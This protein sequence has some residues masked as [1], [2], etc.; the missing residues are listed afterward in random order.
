MK[1]NNLSKGNSFRITHIRK[2][3]ELLNR[4]S[5]NQN[6]NA[7][8]IQPGYSTRLELFEIDD[9]VISIAVIFQA[10]VAQPG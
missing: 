7:A 9:I 4:N 2:K 5:L 6:I 3:R 8:M 10:A 1:R